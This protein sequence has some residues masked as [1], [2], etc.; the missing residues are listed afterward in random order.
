MRKANRVGP[1]GSGS[2]WLLEI[3]LWSVSAAEF[4]R[5]GR[6]PGAA[7]RPVP[8][9]VEKKLEPNNILFGFVQKPIRMSKNIK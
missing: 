5:P 9:E 7:F 2:E 3:N 8:S 6:L 4:W 1:P